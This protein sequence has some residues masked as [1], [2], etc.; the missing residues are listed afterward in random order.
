[1]GL[2]S[3]NSLCRTCVNECKQS[4]KVIVIY[5]PLYRR[6]IVKSRHRM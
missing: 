5:C 4:A 6:K 3:I 1:M 2:N